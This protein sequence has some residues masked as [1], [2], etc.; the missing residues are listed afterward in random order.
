MLSLKQINEIPI[1]CW[2]ALVAT[3]PEGWAFGYR[4]WQNVILGVPEWSLI[5]HSFGIFDNDELLAVVPLQFD[6]RNSFLA[7]TGWGGCGPI[8]SK[9]AMGSRR[10]LVK[11][12][13]LDNIHKVAFLTRA[14]HFHFTVS[15]V[16][17]I[18]CEGMGELD[19]YCKQ[20][21]RD[22][23]GVAH[24]I[25]LTVGESEL[26][27]ALSATA[28]Y[29]VKKAGELGISV[30]QES[31]ASCV[32]EYYRVHKENYIRTGVTPHPR[33]YFEGIAKEMAPIGCS[34]L[35]VARNRLGAA[36]GFHND[37]HF[38]KG[39]WY[40]TGCSTDAGLKS[41][42]NYLLFWEA[43]RGAKISG[44]LQYDCGEIFPG[45][46]DEKS[47]GL[48]F[49]KTRFGGAPRRYMRLVKSFDIS[50]P[51][52]RQKSFAARF[53][54]RIFIGAC[55]IARRQHRVDLGRL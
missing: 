13:V 48:T 14:S 15:P 23:S 3:S 51:G 33:A 11:L 42:A 2:D 9:N 16:T 49:F 55:S 17:E 45:T 22:N 20:G 30:S 54:K 4:A 40:H 10:D 47:K 26:W 12:A 44:R 34:V 29:T 18:A 41:G 19:W 43:I 32:H 53:F 25:N 7:S 21:F 8:L 39:A 46:D 52:V 36:I 38:K 27:K 37:V 31:W 1:E 24:V 6:P 28:R 35:W 5:D 50:Q